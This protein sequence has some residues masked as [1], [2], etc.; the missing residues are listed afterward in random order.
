[1]MAMGRNMAITIEDGKGN[2]AASHRVTYGSRIHVDEGDKVKQG[3]RLAEWDPYTR[4]VLTDASGIVDFEDVVD[5]LSVAENADESTGITKRV[6]IDWRANPRG[7]DLKPAIVIND[8]NGKI[9]K[10][11]ERG[12]EARFLLSV[13]AVLSVE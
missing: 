5:G 13:D 12:G 3:E 8:K 10:P 4:P 2:E 9:M 11:A 6:V 1:M 7:I